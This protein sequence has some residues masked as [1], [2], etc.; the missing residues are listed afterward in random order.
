MA[1]TW[2]TL[3]VNFNT[4]SARHSDTPT[5]GWSAIAGLGDDQD[6]D[7]VIR[8]RGSNEVHR[9][10]IHGKLLRLDVGSA[11]CKAEP[12]DRGQDHRGRPSLPFERSDVG[13]KLKQ[14]GSNLD[15]A[16]QRMS[17]SRVELNVDELRSGSALYV[18]ASNRELGL[19]RGDPDFR[20]RIIDLEGRRIACSCSLFTRCHG[21]VLV[22]VFEE[23]R[24]GLLEVERL[25]PP[26]D[27]EALT[28]AECQRWTWKQ[29]RTKPGFEEC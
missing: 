15:S 8:P 22:E 10:S 26:T 25:G 21:G 13:G 12:H 29:Q 7:L 4:D 18:G 20:K 27:G 9:C 17:S 23:V 2:T 5:L 6:G 28:V 1:F 19:A 3:Q 16:E 11:E 14:L 24:S